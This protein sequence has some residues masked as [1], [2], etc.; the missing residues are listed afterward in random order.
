[1][2]DSGERR[3]LFDTRGRRRNVIRV[4]YGVLA[5]LMGGSLF[6]TVGPFSIAELGL[7]G[8]ST[9]AEDVFEE[10]AERIEGRLAK[11]PNDEG[12]LLALTRA[13]IN[14][15][16][17]QV[18]TDPQTGAQETPPPEAR[19]DYEAALQSWKRYLKLAGNDPN[20]S[21]AQLVSITY[22]RLAEST[23]SLLEIQAHVATATKA[24]KIVAEQRPSI[25]SLTSLAIYQYF[26]GEFAAADRTGKRAEAKAP[27]KPEA[28]SVKKQLAEYRQR[29][30]RFDQRRKQLAKVQKEVGEEQGGNPFGGFGPG[31]APP[32]E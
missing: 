3:M 1:M 9:S 15:A 12:Q 17:A 13:R 20:P 8:G 2:A 30:K 22:F 19:D 5:L 14:A 23:G 24:Q 7:G 25:G 31:A 18:G 29:A 32:G 11:N 28:E 27:S 10:Q 21:V 26:N 6:L 4:V 16:N